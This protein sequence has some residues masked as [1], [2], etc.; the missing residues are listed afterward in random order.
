MEEGLALLHPPLFMSAVHAA[1]PHTNRMLFL[2]GLCSPNP[3]H[4][5]GGWGNPVSPAPCVRARPARGRGYGGT[6]FPHVHFSRPC[7]CAAQR[8][9]EHTVILGRAAPSH[10]LPRVGN[11]E[12]R[13][14]HSPAGR[15]RGETRFPHTPRRGRMF[16]LALH[17]APPHTDG[18]N[19]L[20]GRAQPSQT[21]PPGR[22]MGKPGFP[23]P[24]LQQPIF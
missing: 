19:I 9:N 15:G 13:F 17:A 1:A 6:G 21:L 8:R 18:M 11:G 22:G 10:T 3:S 23:I 2:G 7:G 20:L 12:T 16:T 4:R 24:L 14:P 5:M